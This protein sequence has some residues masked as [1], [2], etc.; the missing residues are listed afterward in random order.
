MDKEAAR[1]SEMVQSRKER[2]FYDLSLK[3]NNP[4]TSPKAYWSVMK[5]CYH[6]RKIPII[7]PLSVIQN[8]KK[9]LKFLTNIF[10]LNEALCQ[11]TVSYQK[12]NH[13]LRKQNYHV[14]ILRMKIYTK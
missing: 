3:F 7:P 11:I 4:Q 5:S 1:L 9:R 6:G 13:I 2:Y 8:L 14:S 10:R 12:I